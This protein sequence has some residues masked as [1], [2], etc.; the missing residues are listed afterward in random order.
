MIK[1]LHYDQ[2]TKIKIPNLRNGQNEYINHS[3]AIIKIDY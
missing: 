1:N 3:R 2:Q